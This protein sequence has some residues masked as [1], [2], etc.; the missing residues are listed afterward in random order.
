MNHRIVEKNRIT[1][2]VKIIETMLVSTL[3]L[4]HID[5]VKDLEVDQYHHLIVNLHTNAI[6]KMTNIVVMIV[7]VVARDHHP[8]QADIL[9]LITTAAVEV[10]EPEGVAEVLVPA[11]LVLFR[12]LVD[13]VILLNPV[14]DPV[15]DP[16]PDL[17]LAP[18]LVTENMSSQTWAIPN[19]MIVHIH[20]HNT[21]TEIT[22]TSAHQKIIVKK[23]SHIRILI[24]IET[25]TP[26]SLLRTRNRRIHVQIIPVILSSQM[27]FYRLINHQRIPVHRIK[28][29]NRMKKSWS[30]A[31]LPLCLC[32]HDR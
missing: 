28:R 10:L 3:N 1:M 25:P 7:D 27:L 2:F 29:L 23:A 18:V 16:I 14:L 12:H 31:M 20:H 24:L 9:L 19:D 21:T 30:R 26:T 11:I 5:L 32:L 6:L 13:Q 4:E 8:F 22:K 17:V 15:P